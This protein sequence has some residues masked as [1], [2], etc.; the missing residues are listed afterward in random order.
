MERKDW[1]RYGGEDT[2]EGGGVEERNGK[3]WRKWSVGNEW[4]DGGKADGD[5]DD[6]GI[7]K[8][9]GLKENNAKLWRKWREKRGSQPFPSLLGSDFITSKL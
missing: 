7:D 1:Q 8:G 2:G 5:M 3:L 4:R 6:K 9:V